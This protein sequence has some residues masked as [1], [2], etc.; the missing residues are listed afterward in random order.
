M[1]WINYNKVSFSIVK[2]K[3]NLSEKRKTF[4]KRNDL[5]NITSY[6]PRASNRLDAHKQKDI[7]FRYM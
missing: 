3:A 5:M 1:L 4:L 2:I 6:I 7:G